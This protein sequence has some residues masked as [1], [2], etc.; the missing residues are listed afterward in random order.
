MTASPLRV[1]FTSAGRR[2]GLLDCFRHAA[3]ELG[4][5][6]ELHA[7]DLAPRLSAACAKADRSFGVSPC[8]GPDYIDELLDHCRRHDIRLLVPTIDT[9]LVP[10]SRAVDR[11]ASLGCRVH[12]G[13]PELI[14]IVRDKGR[15]CRVLDA[16][17]VPVPETYSPDEARA[18]RDPAKWPM[19]AKPAAGSASRGLRVVTAPGDVPSLF[20]EEFILQELLRG[21]EYTVNVFVDQHGTLRAAIPHL[22]LSV[23][24]GEV[25][26]GRTVRDERFTRIARDLVSA[27]PQPR[28]AMCFQLMDDARRGP[29]VFEI[30]A[31]FGGGYPL[32]DRAGGRFA[33]WLLEE[34]LERES[35]ASDDWRDGVEMLRFDAAVFRDVAGTV[36]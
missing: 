10:L 15:T 28:G 20:E 27:L 13:P 14:D 34:V 7:C 8:T 24:A 5:A 30:N 4:I 17:G 26:K 29:T 32:A 1:L 9:E 6:V 18:L 2:V 16:A 25:E 22:R 12:V 19:L 11:F 23:R 3:V 21:P 36:T 31:R 33:L 35:S